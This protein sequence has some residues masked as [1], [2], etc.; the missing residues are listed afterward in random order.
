R[1][2]NAVDAVWSSPDPIGFLSGTTNLTESRGNDP[3]NI[4]D[5]SGECG[6]IISSARWQ[7]GGQWRLTGMA[8]PYGP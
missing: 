5:P 8:L 3:M 2:Y 1:W 4:V 6:R 7:N